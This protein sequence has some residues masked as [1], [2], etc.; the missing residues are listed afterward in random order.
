LQ[1]VALGAMCALVSIL[2][3]LIMR[4]MTKFFKNIL[5]IPAFVHS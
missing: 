5:K 1:T 2:F 3:L 4:I